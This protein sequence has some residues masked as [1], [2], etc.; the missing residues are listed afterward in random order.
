MD[1]KRRIAP[2]ILAPFTLRH[3]ARN[4][5]AFPAGRLREQSQARCDKGHIALVTRNG[6][7]IFHITFVIYH[8]APCA[9][10][11]STNDKRNMEN[12]KWGGFSSAWPAPEGCVW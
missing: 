7:S 4:L 11:A 3:H 10:P 1:F 6:F 5:A 8:C 2:N 12:G 9:V